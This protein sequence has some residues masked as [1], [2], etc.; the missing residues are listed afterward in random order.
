MSGG[1][2]EN[3]EILNLIGYGLSK[4]DTAFTITYGFLSKQKFYEYI[5]DIGIAKTTGTVKN[6]QDLF[7]GME[8]S[9][10]RKGWWQK[11]PVYKFRKDYIDSL[12]GNLGVEDFVDVVK[13]SIKQKFQDR[14]IDSQAFGRTT[15]FPELRKGEE[16]IKAKPIIQSCFKQMQIT[17][18]EAEHYFLGNYK[19]IEVFAD[20]DIA[21]ARLLGDGYDFQLSV[22]TQYY[23]AEVKGLRKNTGNIRMTQ[24]EYQRAS[25]YSNDYVLVV[26]SDLDDIPK[27][28]AFFNPL[29]KIAF[30]K[31]TISTEQIVYRSSV[32]L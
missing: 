10:P 15:L 22:S 20:A 27:M 16:T 19:M 29:H 32:Q 14:H 26:V 1:R 12:F 18:S 24:K 21:D 28:T 25:E 3:Y 7:D 9:G 31:Q 30:E 13:L 2:H 5:V 8:T 4:F 23:L 17:G 6:R 11:G